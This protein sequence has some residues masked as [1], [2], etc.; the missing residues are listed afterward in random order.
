MD[1][2]KLGE[3]KTDMENKI[4]ALQQAVSRAKQ[5][6]LLESEFCRRT[7]NNMQM[8]MKQIE[9]KREDIKYVI[10]NSEEIQRYTQARKDENDEMLKQLERTNK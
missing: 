10:S 7:E 5:Q 6:K 8:E 2:V 9:D 1:L 3:E 4:A